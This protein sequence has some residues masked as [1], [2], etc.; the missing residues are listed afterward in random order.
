MVEKIKIENSTEK[1]MQICIEP[2]AEYIDWGKGKMVE[3]ELM[4]I[5]NGYADE[6]NIA[7]TQQD[8]IIYECRQYEIKI[9][10]DNE[11]KYYTPEDRYK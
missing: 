6:L 5:N 4:L 8:L 1:D 9:F 11:L 10:I 3:I 2:F 7:L